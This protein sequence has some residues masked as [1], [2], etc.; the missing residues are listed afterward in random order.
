MWS[1]LGSAAMLV[2]P[3]TMLLSFAKV[4][5][6]SEVVTADMTGQW[7]IQSQ[8]NGHV[9]LQLSADK[10]KSRASIRFALTE[11]QGLTEEQLFSASRVNFRLVREA[12]IF[13]FSGSFH[14]GTG[15]GQW[16]FNADPAFVSLLRQHGYKQTTNVELYA[17]A[18]SDVRGSYIADLE[19]EGYRT[20]PINQLVGLYTNDVSVPYIK[21]LGDV[22]YK[23]LTA[24]QLI[25]L[26][27]NGVTRDYIEQLARRGQ[28]NL[29]V[30]RLLS[31][32]TNPDPR[33]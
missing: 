17:L 33:R 3:M 5:R 2:L 22:G 26:R 10:G 8:G 28:K 16:T 13:T 29:T 18:V 27:T 7:S 32:R 24:A 14:E 12:G 25:S 1:K 9:R 30:E 6:S 20:V 23:G 11:F 21:S 15:T 31:L 4:P 19:R